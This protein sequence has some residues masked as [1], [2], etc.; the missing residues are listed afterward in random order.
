LSVGRRWLIAAWCVL[1]MATPD[2]IITIAENLLE[3]AVL[4][5]FTL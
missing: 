2:A 3:K 5:K 4:V 1:D